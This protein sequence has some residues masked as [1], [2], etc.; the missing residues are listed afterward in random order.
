[1]RRIALPLSLLAFACQDDST[2]A[3]TDTDASSGS[4]EDSSSSGGTT[5]PTSTTLTTATT[6][7]DSSGTTEAASSSSEDSDPSVTVTDPDTGPQSDC[8]DGM[9]TENEVCEEGDFGSDTCMTQGFGA[10]DLVCSNDCL[11]FSTEGCYTCGNENIEGPEECDGE[12]DNSI[13]CESEGYTE[14]EITCVVATCQYDVSQCTLCGDGVAEGNESCDVA[15]FG[16]AT[17]ESIGF[18]GG[19]LDCDAEECGL[20]VASCTGGSFTA[21]FETGTFPVQFV[22]SGN[23]DWVVDNTTPL[24]GGFS[25]HSGN[26]N[27]GQNS[28][29]RLDVGFAADGT[30]AFSHREDCQQFSDNLE[31]RVDGTL[32]NSWGGINATAGASFPVDAGNHTLEW[33]YTKDNF[34]SS[35][36]DTVFIDNVVLTGGVAL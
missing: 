35:G 17:C 9:I 1:M 4:A 33:R 10:G 21:D 27:D 25:A 18:D 29:L 2:Q 36:T 6:D 16:G 24:F 12:L 20:V 8:G 19:T 34:S 15:D 11:G 3:T 23:E 22:S 26:I 14:G 31:F 13:D 32:F 5:E 30:V 7:V 28:I